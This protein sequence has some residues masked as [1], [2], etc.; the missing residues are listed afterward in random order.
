MLLPILLNNSAGKFK[1][2]LDVNSHDK[3]IV[4]HDQRLPTTLGRLSSYDD[5]AF[6]L[7]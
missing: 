2:K 3:S 5:W 1:W 4:S 7:N 6:E